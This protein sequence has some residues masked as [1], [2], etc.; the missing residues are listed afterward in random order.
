LAGVRPQTPLGE[1]TAPHPDRL[2]IAGFKW[3]YFYSKS[4]E[5][6]KRERKDGKGGCYKM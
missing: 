5:G 2:P 4:R 3:T 1:L 6:M